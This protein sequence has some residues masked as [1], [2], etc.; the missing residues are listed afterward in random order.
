MKRKFVLLAAVMCLCLVGCLKTVTP[1]GETKYSIDPN[2]A[3]KIEVIAEPVVGVL[4]A[5][6]PLYPALIPFATA[7]GGAFAA[8][9]TQ[10]PKLVK[11]QTEG[12]LYQNTTGTLVAILEKFKQTNPDEWAKL[13]EKLA[14]KIGPETENVIRVLRG[15]PPKT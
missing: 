1:D 5:L 7:L 12:E 14:D 4:Q 8:W 6:A 11:A 9:K 2:K 10:K 3:E 15:L 13:E